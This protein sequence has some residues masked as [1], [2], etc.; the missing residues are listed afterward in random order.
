MV[1]GGNDA[2][3]PGEPPDVDD[4]LIELATAL[5]GIARQGRGA[6]LAEYLDAGVPVNLTN[7]SGDSL[8]MLAAY[9]GHAETL[10]MLL[11]RG[12]DPNRVNDKGQTPLA[13]AVFKGKPE[14]V[15]LLVAAGADPDAG[16][17]SA[18]QAAAL[19]ARPD[20]MELLRAP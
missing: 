9:H 12:A 10:A 2:G 18:T 4:D 19:F 14:V 15:R 7:Q 3:V 6:E 17:P 13:G 8:V 20:L 1:T 5:F 16:H 11:E